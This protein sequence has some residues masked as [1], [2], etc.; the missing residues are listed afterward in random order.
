MAQTNSTTTNSPSY[1]YGL[2]Q[3]QMVELVRTHHPDMLENEIRVYLNLALRQFTKDTKLLR[4]V[5]TKTIVANQR[6][7][8]IDDEII[9]INLVYA[10]NTLI[11]RLGSSPEKDA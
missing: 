3:E 5:F 8:Q 2:T 4:G 7:Y 10:D 11:K 6:W 9:S 1:G